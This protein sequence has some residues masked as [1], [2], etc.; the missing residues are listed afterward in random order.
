MKLVSIMAIGSPISFV[1]SLKLDLP[2][3]LLP[4]GLQCLRNIYSSM[5]NSLGIKLVLLVEEV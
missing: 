5:Q 3:F 2:K 4:Y 1:N